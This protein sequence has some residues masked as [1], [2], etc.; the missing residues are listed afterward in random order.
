M[1]ID[2][3]DQ[4]LS[5]R[6]VSETLPNRP[7]ISTVWRWITRGIRGVKLESTLIGGTRYTSHGALEQFFADSN[8]VGSGQPRRRRAGQRK[9]AVKKAKDALAKSGI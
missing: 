7:H 8:A 2:H 4:L 1:P 5:I 6:D 3:N 9:K